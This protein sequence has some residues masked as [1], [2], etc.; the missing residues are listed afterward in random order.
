MVLNTPSNYHYKLSHDMCTLI[1][2]MAAVITISEIGKARKGQESPPAVKVS[3]LGSAS[4]QR[5][6]CSLPINGKNARGHALEDNE[7]AIILYAMYYT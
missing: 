5:A 7:E 1:Y 2:G 6:A 3:S 4:I